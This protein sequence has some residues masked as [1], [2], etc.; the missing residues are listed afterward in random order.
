M[1]A[2]AAFL[3]FL[4]LVSCAPVPTA[5]PLTVEEVLQQ[6]GIH[7]PRDYASLSTCEQVGLY[8]EVGAEFLDLDHGY[9]LVPQ[10][11]DEQL[12]REPRDDIGDCIVEIGTSKLGA[13]TGVY[14]STNLATSLAVHALIY[15]AADR[16]LI[17]RSDVRSF[18]LAAMCDSRLAYRI[19]SIFYWQT[20]VDLS[21]SPNPADLT[22]DYCP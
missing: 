3:M 14:D 4:G 2:L 9:A 11:M 19:E 16:R 22:D 5:V 10:W 15:K 18:V 13:L 7:G 8:A 17:A 21:D 1:K 12:D 6:H 20:R